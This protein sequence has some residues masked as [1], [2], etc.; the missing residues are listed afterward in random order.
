MINDNRCS[1][2]VVGSIRNQSSTAV[3]RGYHYHRLT[4]APNIPLFTSAACLL[5]SSFTDVNS[6]S[7]DTSVA[8]AR[9][10]SRL[11]YLRHRGDT[12]SERIA[13]G[14]LGAHTCDVDIANDWSTDDWS[15]DI[16]GKFLTSTVYSV[17]ATFSG[18]LCANRIAL[19]ALKKMVTMHQTHEDF[20]TP[21]EMSM[22]NTAGKL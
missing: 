20:K 10:S 5:I 16:Q 22:H 8:R 17:G 15:T 6:L 7:A 9:I 19:F 14:A 12:L 21:R 2:T 11:K 13:C 3:G 18:L 1:S 4:G